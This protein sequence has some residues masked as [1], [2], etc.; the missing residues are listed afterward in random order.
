MIVVMG[1]KITSPEC[2]ENVVF[3]STY[4]CKIFQTC[5][6]LADTD[7]PLNMPLILPLLLFMDVNKTCF[8]R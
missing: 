6:Q 8:E 3:I 4:A 1:V 2:Q 7:K 5:L